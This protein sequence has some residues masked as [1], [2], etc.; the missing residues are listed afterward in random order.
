MSSASRRDARGP[1]ERGVGPPAPVGR[2][3]APAAPRERASG[4]LATGSAAPGRRLRRLMRRLQRADEFGHA[5]RRILA[6]EQA[7]GLPAPAEVAQRALTVLSGELP[8]RRA[9]AGA[10]APLGEIGAVA[11]RVDRVRELL[12]AARRR[13]RGDGEHR[14][15]GRTHGG[16]GL[17]QVA[18]RARGGIAQVRLRDY[19]QVGDL[20]DPRLQELQHV[21]GCWLHHHRN[22]VT[23]VLDIGLRLAHA[24]RLDHHHVERRCQGLG[25]LPSGRGEAAQ[26]PPGGCRADQH[27]VV[28]RVVLDARTVAEQRAAGA[29]A[30]RVHCEDGDGLFALAP[31]RDEHRQQ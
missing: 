30:R 15:L 28:A 14:H 20:H 26:P 27:A 24:H 22:G 5:R 21:S 18:P 12:D 1:V 10:H 23:H 9:A 3:A 6:L 19:E 7:L 4:L 13:Y 29:L 31:L 17:R 25:R 11:V 16:K 2:G 8:Q